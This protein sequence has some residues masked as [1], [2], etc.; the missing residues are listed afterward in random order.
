MSLFCFD[1][2]ELHFSGEGGIDIPRSVGLA[3]GFGIAD[4][5]E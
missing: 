5:R 1:L 2:H 3:T 4:C